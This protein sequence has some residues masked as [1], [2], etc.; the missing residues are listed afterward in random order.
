M[1]NRIIYISIKYKYAVLALTAAFMAA[2]LRELFR[3]PVDAVPD[4]TNN[5]VQVITTAPALSTSDVE[6]LITFPLEQALRTIP[7][8][9]EMRSFSRSGLSLITLVF[10]D[11]TDIYWARQQIAEKLQQVRNQMPASADIPYMAPVTTGLGEIYQYV[12]RPSPGYEHKYNATALRTLQDWVVRRQL[13]GVEGVAD[14]SSFGG[15]VLQYE[16]AFRP[17]LLRSSGLTPSD[18]VQAL[19]QNNKNAGGAYIEKNHRAFFIRSEGFYRNLDEVRNTVVGYTGDGIPLRIGDIAEV[20]PGFA[21]PYGAMVFNDS[22]EVAGG[23]VMM[24]KGQNGNR[25]VQRV[26]ERVEEIRRTLP[27]GVLLEP[28]LDRSKMVN[29]VLETVKNNLMEGALI[30]LA[31]LTLM[32]GSLRA[33]LLVASVIPLSFLFAVTLMNRFGISGNL[34][35]LGAL[36][37]GLLV[38]GAVI[39]VEGV[40]HTLQSRLSLIALPMSQQRLNMDELVRKSAAP[41]L[42][43]TLFG[44]LI[45]IV[46][47]IPVL[48]L[49]GIEGKMFRPMAWTVL[50]ALT[51]AFLLSFT[52]VPAL[53]A[54]V[55]DLKDGR[56]SARSKRWL[57]PIIAI[58]QKV[59][60][61]SFR[62]TYWIA[63]FV[64]TL[65]LLAG[66][67]GSRLGGE[68]IPRLPEGD[69]AIETRLPVG[70]SLSLS[71]A[72]VK[73]A[74]ALLLRNFPEIEKIVAKTGSGEIPT[75]PMPLEASDLMV[76]LKDR[77]G[78]TTAHTWD[79]LIAKIKTCLD[80]LPQVSFGIQYPVAMRFNELLTGSRQDVVCKIF[81]EN[82]DS[83]I[84]YANRLKEVAS[85]IEGISEIYLENIRGASEVV[86]Q[87]D[88]AQMARLGA[89]LSSLNN[90]LETAF[91]GIPVGYLY[92]NERRFAL[93]VRLDTTLRTQ[94][95]TLL[96]LP[97]RLANGM[98]IPLGAMATVHW[99]EAINQIQR[100]NA[101]RRIVVGF[102]VRGRDVESVVQDI[103]KHLS[104]LQLAPGYSVT[105]SGAYENLIT[106]RQRLA[107]A[108][109]MALAFI[110]AFLYLAFGQW[111]PLVVIFFTVPLSAIGGIM[112]LSLRQMPFSVSAGIG[113]IV[114]FGVAVL[115]GIVLISEI[116]KRLNDNPQDVRRAALQASAVRLRPILVTA[117]VAAMGFLPMA[118]SQGNGAE[119]QRPLATVVIGGL[120]LAT[121]MTLIV[122]PTAYVKLHE[123]FSRHNQITFK[124]STLIISLLTALFTANPSTEAQKILTLDQA[125]DSALRQ[126][127]QMRMVSLNA[128]YFKTLARGGPDIN[129]PSLDLNLGQINSAYRD[130]GIGF[131][132][133]LPFPASL[134]WEQRF[135]N[136]QHNE[137]NRIVEVRATEVKRESLLQF[138]HLALLREKEK[139]LR[140]TD[141]FLVAAAELLARRVQK[142]ESDPSELAY[143][144]LQRATV[145]QQVELVHKDIFEA[146]QAFV[147]LTGIRQ[148]VIPYLPALKLEPPEIPAGTFWGNKSPLLLWL[149]ERINVSRAEERYSRTRL[150]PDLSV[151]F[152]SL[153]ITGIGAD[154]VYYNRSHRFNSFQVGITLP[155]N[156]RYR[157]AQIQGAR[158]QRIMA[159]ERYNYEKAALSI[160]LN[161]L[162]SRLNDLKE[163]LD[164]MEKNIL[165]ATNELLYL[166]DIKLKNGA[167]SGTDWALQT[168]GVLQSRLTYLDHVSEWN[169]TVI[170][171]R[172][173]L[174]NL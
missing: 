16:A 51:G 100:E 76:I 149:S 69:L 56:R 26:K 120:F 82:L 107:I 44:Q 154:N 144:R 167:L 36:D 60:K 171:L 143:A 148:E 18:L 118:L 72:T 131:H 71:V 43:S 152:L 27:E 159:E 110:L 57:D 68:F 88:R 14:V 98:V 133:T 165:P 23:I 158:L 80:S 121:F 70:S 8:L 38:D 142:G 166:A 58:Q 169:R 35:S 29:S 116:Q 33:G 73:S 34:M 83:L 41:L 12:L 129:Q 156:Y 66:F 45:I 125:L 130:N 87:P 170:E 39:V 134:L 22:L 127:Y 151:G 105:F 96:Q 106:A 5:Q 4:I 162:V 174:N 62:K 109:P 137:N 102:N 97:V 49:Q 21:L 113:F 11:E 59:L 139:I 101:R 19:E 67:A 42:R 150:W 119:V 123:F 3:L 84:T 145:T 140:Q 124:T 108:V 94:P 135:L 65:L 111:L 164:L 122:L 30:V 61:F 52:Y 161:T 172:Y 32:L 146:Y 6:R 47:Y 50:F 104:G 7:H 63:G 93:V 28:F 40:L 31:V 138:C 163:H 168:A 2:G 25:V 77:N 78:W 91:A 136:A 20:R 86:V 17:D 117:L 75:D 155:L 89:D 54:V 128:E 64:V 160:R 24:L 53:S 99:K 173:I 13:L 147:L 85:S 74:S 95:E 132:Y 126:S 79:E 153:T 81:G 103:Q 10:P 9:E 157:S 90:A 55:L 37:F 112:A 1:I 15:R 48:S 46:V 114:L 141:S 92:E 115:N